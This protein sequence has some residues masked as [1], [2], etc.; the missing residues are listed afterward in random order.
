MLSRI[1]NLINPN[2]ATN[3]A[4]NLHSLTPS[5]VAKI[6]AMPPQVSALQNTPSAAVGQVSG[7]VVADSIAPET[8]APTHFRSAKLIM[9][10]PD[11]NNKFYEMRENAD[12]TFT[13][14]YG[15]VGNRGNEVVY[16]MR[17]W[18]TKIREK[19]RKGYKD[20]T[21]LFAIGGRSTESQQDLTGIACLDVRQLMQD[22]M[23]YARQS[24]SHNYVV[25]ADK[26][27][28]QQVTEAQAIVDKLVAMTHKN[29]DL[30]HFNQLLIDL[31]AVI[32]RRMAD[33]KE[34]LIN[35]SQD[36]KPIEDKLAE[37]QAT[38]DVMRGQ[39]E[40]NEQQNAQSETATTPNPH[41]LDAMGLT[42]QTVT[43]E[44][45][46]KLIKKMMGEDKDKFSRAFLLSNRQTEAQFN[47]FVKSKE[48]QKTTLFWHGSRNE[49]WLSILKTGLVLRPANAVITGKMF[50]YGLY[51][52]D[53]CRKSLNYTSLRGSYWSGGNASKAYLAIYEVHTGNPL[54]IKKHEPFCGNLTEARLKERGRAYD[55]VF[56]EGGYDLMNNE[57][58]VYNENQCTIKYLVEVTC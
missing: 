15:R 2:A 11:N 39:V 29:L 13:V 1:L 32:P 21:H 49:N 36:L 8:A 57:Y 9:V 47:Q 5:G 30:V 44:K 56:A 50:G 14:L 17:E 48:N 18:D 42:A 41:I 25:T 16:P 51:F 43:D 54:R 28:R 46:L 53:K 40:I 58:I 27:T 37:E 38:L 31:Y 35:Q 19:T 45:T 22:L 34:Y 55:S 3:A 26:V 7:T 4:A 24:I 52:A 6:I 23:R 12:G 10:T 33:V 20:Q